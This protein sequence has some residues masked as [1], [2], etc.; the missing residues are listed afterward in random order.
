[1]RKILFRGKHVG[2]SEWIY[3]N[4]AP[5]CFGSFPCRPAI[6]PVSDGSWEPIEIIVDSLCMS[7]GLVDCYGNIIFE[8]D[9][10]YSDI[11][12]SKTVVFDEEVAAF[13]L[14]DHSI[15]SPQYLGRYNTEHFEIIGN[16]Y[17]NPELIEVG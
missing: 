13:C 4:Y 7:T 15:V 9:I 11:C 3:G 12:K 17:D 6:V 14:H 1:M 10:I 16:I 8:G 2:T 5:V